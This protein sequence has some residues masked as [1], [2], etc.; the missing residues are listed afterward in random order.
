MAEMESPGDSPSKK[1]RRNRFKWG[2][3]STSILYQ[4]YEDQK[5]PSKEE[6]YVNSAH[7]GVT[8][9]VILLL[10]T[11]LDTNGSHLAAD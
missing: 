8:F 5:N 6:R 7:V 10:F 11:G 1:T 2:P 9:P 4:S 3:A